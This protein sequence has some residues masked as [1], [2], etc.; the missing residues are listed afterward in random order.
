MSA[1]SRSDSVLES[2]LELSSEE[3]TKLKNLLEVAE[4][5]QQQLEKLESEF[6]QEKQRQI[7]NLLNMLD[8]RQYNI[9]YHKFY[10]IY[11]NLTCDQLFWCIESNDDKS[12][13][14]TI[15]TYEISDTK[16]IIRYMQDLFPDMEIDESDC[17]SDSCTDNEYVHTIRLKYVREKAKTEQMDVEAD[18]EVEL[19]A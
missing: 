5:T 12:V 3:K 19:D 14:F 6:K 4:T 18:A 13:D 7:R 10:T 8:H 16:T 1:V 11:L 17:E 15:H 9:N 2:E